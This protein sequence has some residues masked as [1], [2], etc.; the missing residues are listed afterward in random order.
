MLPYRR[1]ATEFKHGKKSLEVD[2][3]SGG[4][5]TVTTPEIVTKV[6]EIV[7]KVHDTVMGDRRDFCV[8]GDA[9]LMS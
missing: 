7:T 5:L 1:M 8:L 2:P 9:A 3:H 4:P 6:H